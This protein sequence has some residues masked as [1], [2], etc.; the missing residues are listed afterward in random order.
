MDSEKY[1]AT[2]QQV[3]VLARLVLEMPLAEFLN[4]INLAD[5]VCPIVN[6]TLYREFL[7]GE[8]SENL[9]RVERLAWATKNFQ[10]EVRD[11]YARDDK[12]KPVLEQIDLIAAAKV[13]ERRCRIC[14]CTDYE[15][16]YLDDGPCSWVEED[17]CSNP[18]CLE[19]AGRSG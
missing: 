15:P 7:H 6:P 4:A 5:T 14:G 8:G 11:I 19:A 16:C 17:L 13:G 1:V 10:D 9:R 3:L 12:L 2:Q 18:D